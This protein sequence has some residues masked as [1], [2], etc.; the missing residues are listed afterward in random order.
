MSAAE[1]VFFAN[2]RCDQE[3]LIAQLK[4][5]VHA[6]NMPAGDLDSNWAYM[7][8]GSLA[9]NLKA[10]YGLLMPDKAQGRK[11]VRMEFRSFMLQFMLLP[12]Q[13][14]KTGRCLVYRILKYTEQLKAFFATFER[15]RA[16]NFT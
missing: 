12:C 13:V 6:M 9:W 5:G 3:N 4:T 2:D 14:V 15:I 8:I 10:W 7:V 1:V 16:L 11:V